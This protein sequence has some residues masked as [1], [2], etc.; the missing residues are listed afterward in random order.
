MD[1]R[2]KTVQVRYDRSRLDRFIVYFADKRMGEAQVL[3][4]HFNANAMRESQP[5]KQDRQ[6]KRKGEAQ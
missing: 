3:D 4:L 6:T 1:L 5:H 2:Q